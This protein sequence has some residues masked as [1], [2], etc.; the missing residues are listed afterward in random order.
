MSGSLRPLLPAITS[1]LAGVGQLL[2]TL[3]GET[4]R[5]DDAARAHGLQLAAGTAGEGLGLWERELGLQPRPDLD[6]ESR[7]ALVLAALSFFGGC[8]PEGL[9]AL[10]ARL[11]G[12]EV[13]Y[14]ETPEQYTLQLAAETPGRVLRDLPGMARTVSRQ[15]PAHIHCRLAATGDMAAERQTCHVIH[16]G[17][18][19]E[20]HSEG[21]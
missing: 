13:G 4:A 11:V 8:T 6:D 14:T 16:G 9:K 20:M 19:L 2:D 5:L 7:R 1:G 12:G 18:V 21:Q 15:V 10:Y 3:G 17:V